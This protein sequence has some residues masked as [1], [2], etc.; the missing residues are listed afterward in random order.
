MAI[1]K[2][3]IFT[4]TR[5]K[6]ITFTLLLLSLFN[7]SCDYINPDEGIP[8][9]IA[10]DTVKLS[11][12]SYSQGPN[13]HNISDVWVSVNGDFLG[14]FELPAEF[15][16]LQEGSAEI[17]IRAG[18][19]KNGIAASRVRYPFYDNIRI[20][21]VLSPAQTLTFSPTFEYMP[22][23]IFDWFENFEDP[24]ISLDTTYISD[25]GINDSTTN[26]STVASIILKGDKDDF[27]A[28]SINQFTFPEPSAA[29]YLEMDYKCNQQFIFGLIIRSPGNTDMAPVMMINPIDKWNKIYID[30]TYISTTNYTSD[31]YSVYFAATKSDTLSRAEILIDNIKLVHF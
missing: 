1:S 14:V 26:G 23:T 3:K 5:L 10:V 7:S 27:Q 25:V 8:A 31:N 4:S 6:Q 16:V 11:T 9:F 22:E 19:K 18:I 21:T 17:Y 28:V 15:P 29:L 12:I 13:N 2:H 30:L 20:D 24:G